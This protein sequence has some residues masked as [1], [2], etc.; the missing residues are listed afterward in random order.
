MRERLL[1]E[2]QPIVSPEHLT[3]DE[4]RRHPKRTAADGFVN[5]RAKP[6]LH[7]RA[8]QNGPVLDLSTSPSRNCRQLGIGKIAEGT[9][10]VVEEFD[11]LGHS[12]YYLCV[13]M[14]FNLQPQAVAPIILNRNR[15]S[16][17]LA[18]SA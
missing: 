10:I 15:I 12:Q 14:S 6:V 3:I 5:V 11:S 16:Q 13:L 8:H 1:D 18:A 2:I 4:K 9:Q 17:L 7:D